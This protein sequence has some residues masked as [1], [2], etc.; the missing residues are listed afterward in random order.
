MNWDLTDRPLPLTVAAAVDMLLNNLGDEHLAVIRAT[1]YDDLIDHH[2]G[3]GLLIRNLLALHENGVLLEDTGASNADDAA[4][5]VLQAL[6]RR[7]RH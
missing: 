7:L 6:W 5:R 4:L 1:D 2:F 3:A